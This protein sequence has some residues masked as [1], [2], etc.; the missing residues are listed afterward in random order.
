MLIQAMIFRMGFKWMLMVMGYGEQWGLG[1][2]IFHTQLDSSAVPIFWPVRLKAHAVSSM[3]FFLP[4]DSET[5]P[6]ITSIAFTRS[7]I[8]IIYGIDEENPKSDYVTGLE[9]SL[10][11]IEAAM[12]P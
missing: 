12:L 4:Q 2:K 3:N 5:L 9:K 8:K 6:R 7:I 11:G 10:K 1:R